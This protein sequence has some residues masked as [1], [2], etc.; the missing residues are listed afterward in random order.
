MPSERVKTNDDDFFF[1]FEEFIAVRNKLVEMGDLQ[2]AVLWSISFDSAGRRNE[3]F[4]IK[5]EGLLD[6]NKTNIVRGKRGKMF[7]LIYLDDTKELIRQYLEQRSDD[8]IESLWYAEHGGKRTEVT[9]DALYN[10]F[11]KCSKILSEIRGQETNIFP[12]SA[13]HSRFNV[14]NN[15]G[16]SRL[17]SDNGENRVYDLN[18]I[19]LL[20][21]HESSQTTE[22]YL[23]DNTEEMID[24]LFGVGKTKNKSEQD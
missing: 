8:N 7:S 24:S 17:K 6:G 3:I 18:E 21:H 23:K 9:K 2:T 16:D 13:R 22:M 15:G 1:T 19:K 20:A 11:I 10:R 4:Q 12:H 14:L 5:K